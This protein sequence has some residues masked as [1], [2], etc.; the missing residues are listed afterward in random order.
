MNGQ[1]GTTSK[2]MLWTGRILTALLAL[3]PLFDSGV[4]LAKARSAVE[5]TVRVGYSESVIVPI[6]AT[7]LISLLLYLIP[8]TS[9]LGAI[10]LTGYLGGA[11]ATMVRVMDSWFPFPVVIGVL[12]W[13]ARC[14]YATNRCALSFRFEVAEVFWGKHRPIEACRHRIGVAQAIHRGEGPWAD[15]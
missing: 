14:T 10:L 13:V 15:Q 6:G 5:G 8:R 9:I 3:F 11:T 12:V 1:T 2:P 7:L 4:K